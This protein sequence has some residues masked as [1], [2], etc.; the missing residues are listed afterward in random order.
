MEPTSHASPS[1]VS[2]GPSR[3]FGSQVT[4]SRC[5]LMPTGALPEPVLNGG[6]EEKVR[7]SRRFGSGVAL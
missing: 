6:M 3:I 4:D 2:A 1:H 5:V 7:G